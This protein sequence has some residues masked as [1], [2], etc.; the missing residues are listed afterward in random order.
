MA[1]AVRAVVALEVIWEGR[2]HHSSLHLP[3]WMVLVETV[4]EVILKVVVMV[5]EMM[6]ATTGYLSKGLMLASRGL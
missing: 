2:C 4:S 3:D 5:P 1:P 6:V